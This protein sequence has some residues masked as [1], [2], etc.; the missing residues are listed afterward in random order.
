M[1]LLRLTGHLCKETRYKCIQAT[2]T[3]QLLAV[4]FIMCMRGHSITALFVAKLCS[5]SLVLFV[6]VSFICV[7]LFLSMAINS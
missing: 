2:I 1:F 3:M 5:L 6:V 7:V 4:F